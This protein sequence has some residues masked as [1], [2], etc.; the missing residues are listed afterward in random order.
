MP[1][2]REVGDS[3]IYLCFLNPM[4]GERYPGITVRNRGYS[5]EYPSLMV[6]LLKKVSLIKTLGDRNT[7]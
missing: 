4:S 2:P 6:S 1:R 7:T 3:I 5:F